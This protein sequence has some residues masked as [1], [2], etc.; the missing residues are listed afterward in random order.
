MDSSSLPPSMNDAPPPSLETPRTSSSA[1]T[2]F[3]LAASALVVSSRSSQRSLSLASIR[4]SCTRLVLSATRRVGWRLLFAAAILFGWLALRVRRMAARAEQMRFM[5]SQ[6]A[7]AQSVQHGGMGA[8]RVGEGGS[9]GRV[10]VVGGG[11]A[12][13]G[14]AAALHRS[15]FEVSLYEQKPSIGGNGKTM[16]WNVDGQDVTTGLSVLAWPEQLF[17]TY[18]CLMDDLKVPTESHSLRY[19][20]SER[21]SGGLECVFAHEREKDGVGWAKGQWL[22]EDLAKWT[23]L[24]AFVRKVNNFFQYS[25]YPSIYRS[26]FL[27]PMNVVGLKTMFWWFGI[28]ERFWRSIFIP[29]H[30]STF[31]ELEMEGVPAVI[32]ELLDDI[33][34]LATT[35]VMRSWSNDISEVFEKLTEPFQDTVYTSRSV[36]GVRFEEAGGKMT[37]V[38]IDDDD[39][40]EK[41]DKVI[42]ACPA[43]ATLEALHGELSQG[44][45]TPR[46][47]FQRLKHWLE[48]VCLEGVK[49]T[50]ERDPTF[51][52]GL[53]HS[54]AQ[55][56]CPAHWQDEVMAH[57]CNY[58]EVDETRPGPEPNLPYV[59]NT[60]VISSWAPA[61]QKPDVKGK[62]PMLVSYNCLDKLADHHVERN[63]TS[64][65]AH[66]CLTKFH[67]M[68]SALFWPMFQGSR[69]G[70]VFFCGS[71]ITPGNGH[72]LSF[73]SGLVAAAECG[74]EFPYAGNERA[75]GD[76]FKLRKMMTWN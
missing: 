35:P 41:F 66:P 14:A 30:S 28:S 40:E 24:A 57:Y 65:Q 5:A 68:A 12:G 6:A 64:Y 63:V 11:I 42:F 21:N 20:I 43:P 59:E 38:V 60:F 2:G 69:Q 19:F 27:N 44:G 8:R 62:L 7:T 3:L 53:A 25:E 18:N 56:I 4:S 15:G 76:F 58:V 48:R 34:P 72:D 9:K 31:L 10:C 36:A 73:L 17:H 70:T 37:A 39:V 33:V 1:P 50:T 55:A 49:F 74:A 67:L 13:C 26:S 23:A 71:T 32:A 45:Y 52:M 16:A 54:H 46:W 75:L 22:E 61:A 29:V 51:M 47:P